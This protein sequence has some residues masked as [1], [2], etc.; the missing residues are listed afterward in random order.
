[1]QH[2]FLLLSLIFTVGIVG[3]SQAPSGRDRRRRDRKN[4]RRVRHR[5]RLPVRFQ[6]AVGQKVRQQSGADLLLRPR[7]VPH[8]EVPVTKTTVLLREKIWRQNSPARSFDFKLLIFEY[9][10]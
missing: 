9:V 6:R 8:Q 7:A 5:E 2:N 4:I 3:N 10:S 1:M